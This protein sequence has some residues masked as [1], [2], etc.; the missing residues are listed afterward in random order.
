M[1]FRDLFSLCVKNL[2]R[3]RTRS[4][5]AIIGVVVGTCAVVLMLSIGFGLTASYQ[6]QIESYGNL[7]MINMY[8]WGAGQPGRGSDQKGAIT[9]SSLKEIAAME[10]VTAVTPVISIN[11][12]VGAGKYTSSYT[13]VKGVDPEILEKFKYNLQDGR[14]LAKNDK[15]VILFGSYTPQWF[16]DPQSKNYESKEID[17]MHEKL[18]LTADSYYGMK[19]T[20]IPKDQPQ[21]EIYDVKACGLLE[22]TNDD[23]DYCVYMNIKRVEE[24]Q[25]EIA[26]AEKQRIAP[27]GRSGKEYNQAIV[28]I[29]D[30][31]Y[32]EKIN[33][34]LKDAGYQTSSPIDWLQAMKETANMIQSILGGIGGISL[35]VAALSITNTMVMSVYERTREIGVMKVIGANLSDIKRLFLVEA[36]L[37]GFFGG[38]VGVAISLILSLLMNTVLYDVVST[39]LGAIGGGYGTTVSVVP[40]WLVFAAIAFATAIGVGA[41]YSP[42]NRAMKMSA[43]E[44]LKNE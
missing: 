19:E 36:G 22:E 5:L 9:D 20:D 25:K 26:K 10:G 16:C 39:V 28:Y 18:V 38:V 30:L 2:L 33:K 37:I 23:S 3:R 12:T 40:L 35:L 6:A 8:N 15:D 24:Y 7:H 29:E 21:Y 43:L 42:A 44:S 1:S 34:E 14:T 13:E 32:V 4:L 27:T 31:N 11:M 17:V 41:G